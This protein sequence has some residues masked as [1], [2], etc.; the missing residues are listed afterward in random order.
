MLPF[1]WHPRPETS[2]ARKITVN[3]CRLRLF[4]LFYMVLRSIRVHQ[5]F[6]LLV[7]HE[8]QDIPGPK[9]HQGGEEPKQTK[10]SV[11]QCKSRSTSNI[12]NNASRVLIKISLMVN[13]QCAIYCK[14]TYICVRYF[15]E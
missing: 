13:I 10:A 15:A 11:Y 3:I 12:I 6:N 8:S 9:P 4:A 5:E 1:A 14:C 7:A 2:C